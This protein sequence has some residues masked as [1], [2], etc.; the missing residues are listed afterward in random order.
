[1]RVGVFLLAGRF[2]GQDDRSALLRARDAVVAAE[3]AQVADS[4]DQA[5]HQLRE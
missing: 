3:A 5:V 4:R 1:V 2:P